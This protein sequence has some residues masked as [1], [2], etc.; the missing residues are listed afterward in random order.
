[1]TGRHKMELRAGPRPSEL[2]C[3]GRRAA[4]IEATVDQDP[5]DPG[6]T[7][8]LAQQDAMR[9]PGVVMEVVRDDPG[10]GHPEPPVVIPRVGLV[11]RLQRDHRL[12]PIA[13]VARG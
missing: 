3:R 13:P 5:R 6:E 8:C 7:V 2:P 1:M 9:E 10:E 12:F 4:E 11:T